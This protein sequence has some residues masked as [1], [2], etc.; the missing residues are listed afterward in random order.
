M[1][2]TFNIRPFA[3][4]V[5]AEIYEITD[6]KLSDGKMLQL[7]I[8]NKDFGSMFRKPIERD[9]LEARQWLEN[10]IRYIKNANNEIKSEGSADINQTY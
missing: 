6:V 2:I 4:K 10:Q 7:S 3:G 5:R 8:L 1:D 9:Y